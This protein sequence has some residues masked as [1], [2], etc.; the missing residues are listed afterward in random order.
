MASSVRRAVQLL[1]VMFLAGAG[2]GSA[3]EAFGVPVDYAVAEVQ[4]VSILWAPPPPPE[5]HLNPP[6]GEC[7][8]GD[9]KGGVGKFEWG[10]GDVY[11]GEWDEQ[12]RPHGKGRYHFVDG[13]EY[14]GDWV[15]GLKEGDGEM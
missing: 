10:S 2:C 9:C 12:Y 15:H 5:S 3:A 7:V 1:L 8:A 11:E 14:D 6:S 4:P 13:E